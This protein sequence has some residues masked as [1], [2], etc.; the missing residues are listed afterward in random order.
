MLCADYE[1]YIRVQ[2]QVSQTYLVRMSNAP[3]TV[4]VNLFAFICILCVFCF[5]L[6]SCCIIVSVVVGYTWW[7]RS[8]GPNSQILS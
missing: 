4:F 5:I 8:L 1:D 3:S 2:D 6:H 7:D